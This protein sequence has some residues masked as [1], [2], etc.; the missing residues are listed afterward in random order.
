MKLARLQLQPVE[1]VAT[2]NELS[3]K[4]KLTVGQLVTVYLP[5]WGSGAVN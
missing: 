4:D 3:T 2:T 1:Y 5:A